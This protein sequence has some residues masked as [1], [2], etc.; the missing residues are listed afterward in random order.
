[1]SIFAK[2]KNAF[3]TTNLIVKVRQYKDGDH[4]FSIDR[5]VVD[6]DK[7]TAVAEKLNEVAEI[8]KD[9]AENK[10]WKNKYFSQSL[11]F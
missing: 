9:N 11:T 3:C 5:V 8:E 1:M 4:F 10:G 2:D 7:A 6:S